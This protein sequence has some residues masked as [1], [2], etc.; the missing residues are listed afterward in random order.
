LP[1]ARLSPKSGFEGTSREDGM[2][3]VLKALDRD[4]RAA[5]LASFL[6][7]TLDAF[8]FFLLIFVINDIARD[9]S[10]GIAEVTEAITLTLAMRPVGAFVFGLLA[11]R[12]GRKPVL[13]FDILFYSALELA[14]AFSTSIEMLLLFRALFGIGMGGEWGLGASLALET[15]PP[16]ARGAVSGVLQQGYATGN[17]LASVL[18]WTLYD[19]I[20]WR[21]MFIV[22]VIPA[23]LV[24]YLRLKVKESPVWEAAQQDRG[25]GFARELLQSLRGRWPLFFYVVILMACFNSLSHGSQ[26]LFP[27]FLKVQHGLDA[28][29]TG[30]V[31]VVANLGAICGGVLFGAYSERIGRRRA[32]VIAALLIL[33]VVWI[34][35]IVQ[36][37]IWIAAG[38]FLV[39]F[40]VQGAFGTVPVHLNELSPEGARGTFPGFTYQLGNL[41]ASGNQYFQA[42]FARTHGNNFGLAIAAVT[43]AAA[44]LLSLVTWFGPE[45]KGT[46]FAGQSAEPIDR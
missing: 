45:R 39:Q 17:L 6:G 43:A 14:T 40:M 28:R 23:L 41:L 36:N 30:A 2:L 26:D 31:S 19:S 10:T 37:P 4:Q 3:A 11:D 7:W 16:K 21:G 18:Y 34:Y 35:A 32:I 13:M 5:F 29:A 25:A 33:P 22:G 12:F 44:L 24:V 15:V 38:A 20:G 27:T 1:V 9:F 8:D 42:V 46:P